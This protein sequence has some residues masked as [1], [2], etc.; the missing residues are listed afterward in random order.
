MHVSR[1][2]NLHSSII[3]LT[4]RVARF[5]YGIHLSAGDARVLRSSP[6]SSCA[7]LLCEFCV[8]HDRIRQGR[9]VIRKVCMYMPD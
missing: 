5:Y 9:I 4:G 2:C 6:A 1:I 7:R 8:A 3:F